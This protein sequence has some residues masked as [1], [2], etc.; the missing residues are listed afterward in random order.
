MI[1]TT[2]SAISRYPL[3]EFRQDIIERTDGIPLFVEEMTKAVLEAENDEGAAHSRASL[4]RPGSPRKLA[5]ASTNGEAHDRVG[6]AKEIAQIGATP[7]AE[8]FPPSAGCG[9]AQARGRISIG[10]GSPYCCWS[11]LPT[12]CSAA[13]PRPICL[14]TR[15]CKTPRL[16]NAAARAATRAPRPH[17]RDPPKPIHRDCR[18]PA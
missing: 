11:A 4:A 16:R 14:S 1:S 6:P 5:R 8:I 17:R 15:W 9:G 7:W 13:R 3:E 10:A 12:G 18:E 2:L